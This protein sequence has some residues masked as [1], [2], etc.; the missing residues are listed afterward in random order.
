MYDVNVN[1]LGNESSWR[2]VQTR[3]PQDRAGVVLQ[4]QGQSEL[5]PGKAAPDQAMAVQ[6]VSRIGIEA[7]HADDRGIGNPA[8][9]QA[10]DEHDR[11]GLVLGDIGQCADA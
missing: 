2:S 7:G 11:L 5:G 3:Q 10:I 9:P 8:W 1:G 4:C 6:L